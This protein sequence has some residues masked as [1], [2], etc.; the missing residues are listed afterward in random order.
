[1]VLLL[2]FCHAAHWPRANGNG[3]LLLPQKGRGGR[4]KARL[5]F[6]HWALHVLLFSTP[7]F[8]ILNFFS[9]WLTVE[10]GG[11]EEESF[12]ATHCPAP[13]CRQPVGQPIGL[14]SW[15]RRGSQGFALPCLAPLLQ[16]NSGSL[17]VEAGCPWENLAAGVLALMLSPLLAPRMTHKSLFQQ[18]PASHPAGREFFLY[19][20]PAAR[21]S[22]LTFPPSFFPLCSC[23]G[24]AG[25]GAGTCQKPYKSLM[26]WVLIPPALTCLALAFSAALQPPSSSS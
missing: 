3:I 18:Y 10:S 14:C 22:L 8:G 1:M 17:L 20:L 23:P 9:S 13:A 12:L 11:G 2:A 6:L 24:I 5:T 4:R 21:N 15:E 19:Y 25:E 16:P 7:D 26:R